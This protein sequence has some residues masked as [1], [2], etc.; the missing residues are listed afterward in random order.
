MTKILEKPMRNISVCKMLF[1]LNIAF[2]SFISLTLIP[3]IYER[4]A[5]YS[6]STQGDI[7]DKN[8]APNAANILTS[9]KN[10]LSAL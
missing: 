6:G 10:I 5:G 8:P 1:M 3:V 9:P 4:N 7:N 2:S